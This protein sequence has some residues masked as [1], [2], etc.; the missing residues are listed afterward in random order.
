M[1][2]TSGLVDD[3]M[4]AYNEPYGM[5]LIEHIIKVTREGKS[6]TPVIAIIALLLL[7]AHNIF[8]T[9]CSNSVT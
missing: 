8:T 3:V 1:S 9:C 4:F 6:V 7:N 2:Y 5:W